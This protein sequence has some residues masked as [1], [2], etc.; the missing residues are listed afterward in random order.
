MRLWSIVYTIYLSTTKKPP[1]PTVL[2]AIWDVYNKLYSVA[3]RNIRFIREQGYNLV[4]ADD[5]SPTVIS[6]LT[7]TY[8]IPTLFY[9]KTIIR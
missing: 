6:T 1:P 4:G 2:Y 7:N 9:S 8:Y 3:S 5:T